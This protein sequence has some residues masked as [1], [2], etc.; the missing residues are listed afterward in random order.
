METLKSDGKK[1][2]LE[3]YLNDVYE[4]ECV[5]KI[6][7]E[8]V[9]FIQTGIETLVQDLVDQILADDR[10]HQLLSD[11]IDRFLE[12]IYNKKNIVEVYFPRQ[13]DCSLQR[14]IAENASG[15]KTVKST[16]ITV[17]SFYDGTKNNFP[18]EFDFIFPVL[19]LRKHAFNLSTTPLLY[20]IRNAIRSSRMSLY[21]TN[22]CEKHH[23][24]RKINF[25]KFIG[26]HGPACKMQFIYSNGSGEKIPIYVDLVPVFKIIDSNTLQWFVKDVTEYV[27]PKTFR[28]AILSEEK[29]LTVNGNLSFTEIEQHFMKN[30]LSKKHVKVTRILKYLL[31]GNGDGEKLE[32]NNKLSLLD[33]GIYYTSYRIKVLMIYHHEVCTNT[34]TDDLG[35][36]VLQVLKEMST[37][38]TLERFPMF[39]RS[40]YTLRAFCMLPY[41][42]FTIATLQ[43]MQMSEDSYD[44]ER[45]K[46]KSVSRQYLDSVTLLEKIR[47]RCVIL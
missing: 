8:E 7:Q 38:E 44:Y 39:I 4:K 10:I 16:I 35:P 23:V 2:N 32:E 47:Q 20:P 36:C 40:V 14:Y 25:E 41:L 3:L 18:D 30:I 34:D 13:S 45:D 26:E 46:I 17:G 27:K 28:E 19:G 31:N 12:E 24:T 6:E 5:F 1:N 9:E 22:L 15:V 21:Y 33:L 43:S 11:E 37:H 42:K 29:C